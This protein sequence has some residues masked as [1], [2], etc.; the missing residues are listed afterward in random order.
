MSFHPAMPYG[1]EQWHRSQRATLPEGPDFAFTA[2]NRAKFEEF[3]SHYAPENRVS[4]VLHA[5]YLVQEQQG[6]IT[7]NAVRHVAEWQRHQPTVKRHR[8]AARLE[9]RPSAHVRASPLR[10]RRVHRVECHR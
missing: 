5:L 8:C 6:H 3:A 7:N 9:R 10:C 2:D 4:A 1:T